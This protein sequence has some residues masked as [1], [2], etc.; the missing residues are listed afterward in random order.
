[1][2][3]DPVTIVPR[4]LRIGIFHGTAPIQVMLVELI[5]RNLTGKGMESFAAERGAGTNFIL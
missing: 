3:T 2:V 5:A 4:N 1:M